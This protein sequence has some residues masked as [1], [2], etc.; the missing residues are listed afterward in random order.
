MEPTDTR[1]PEIDRPHNLRPGSRRAIDLEHQIVVLDEEIV[2]P[3][4][5]DELRREA[6]RWL[7]EIA[8]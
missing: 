5:N 3:R 8:R 7:S 6:A 2:I 1:V 4:R